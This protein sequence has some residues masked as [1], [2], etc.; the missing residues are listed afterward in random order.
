MGLPLLPV[1]GAVFVLVLAA[2]LFIDRPGRTGRPAARLVEYTNLAA[3]SELSIDLANRR[4]G[5]G[6]AFERLLAYA[7]VTAP[8]RLRTAAAADLARA[9]VKMSPNVFLGIRGV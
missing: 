5:Q 7:A 1:I 6:S 9:R 4:R 3:S 8:R 2:T